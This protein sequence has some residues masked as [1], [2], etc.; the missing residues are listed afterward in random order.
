MIIPSQFH[1]ICFYTQ[2]IRSAISYLRLVIAQDCL[3]RSHVAIACACIC[4]YMDYLLS[5]EK[6]RNVILLKY[7]LKRQKNGLCLSNI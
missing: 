4:A 7:K 2:A 3:M 6:E 5:D 1:S